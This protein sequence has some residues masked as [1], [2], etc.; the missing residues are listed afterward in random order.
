MAGG[1]V[2]GDQ[3][4][5]SAFDILGGFG[6]SSGERVEVGEVLEV[7]WGFGEGCCRALVVAVPALPAPGRAP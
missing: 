3:E 5:V 6:V 7:E 1:V 2:S 4:H